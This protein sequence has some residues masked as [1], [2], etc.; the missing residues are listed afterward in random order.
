MGAHPVTLSTSSVFPEATASG[1]ELASRLGYDGVEVMIGVDGVAAEVDSVLKLRDY[2]QVPVRSLHAPTLIV[3]QLVW[4]DAGHW[5]KLRR[6]AEMA[7]ALDCETVVLHPPFRWQRHYGKT[8]V[9]G[10]RSVGA[11]TGVRFCVENMYPWRT[12]AGQ[13][14][15]YLPHWDPSSQPYEHLCLDLSHAATAQVQ[16]VDLVRAWGRRLRHI[17]LTDGA[18][19]FRDE[20]LTP[21]AGNQRADEVIHTALAQGYAGDF[22]LEV[23]THG[24]G[25]RSRRE[26]SLAEAL[27]WTRA[28]ID[29]FVPDPA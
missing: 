11:E 17:H 19:S 6:T 23:S 12:P 27:A 18:G 29:E 4:R 25:S 1:F 3:T 22:C 20:H 7:L 16:S 15:A 28:R 2:H 14:Q 5:D 21:G 8:F 13:H 24:A 26:E 9:A 10:V